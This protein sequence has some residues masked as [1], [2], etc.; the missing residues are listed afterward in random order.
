MGRFS[1]RRGLTLIETL[2][3]VS[4]IGVL[5]ALLAPA[6]GSAREAGRSAV[7]LSNIRQLQLAAMQHARDHD[8]RYPPGA[9]DF[10]RNLHRWHGS[11]GSAGEA[12]DPREGPLTGYLESAARSS[13]LREC[14]TF[15]PVAQEL[16]SRGAGFE[17]GC[18]GYGYNNAFVGVVRTKGSSGRWVVATDETG[19][20]ATRFADPARTV[21]FT[22]AAL[23]TDRLIEYSFAEPRAWPDAPAYAPDPSTHFRHEGRASVAWLDGHVSSERMTRSAAGWFSEGDSGEAGLGWFGGPAGNELYDYE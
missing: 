19:S 14:P 10:N 22:D 17:T 3:A 12:F 5:I 23:L 7:C 9:Q 15:A 20:R 6:L 8:E 1:V 4:V 16:R 11:R 21:G 2:A 18:G 13:A